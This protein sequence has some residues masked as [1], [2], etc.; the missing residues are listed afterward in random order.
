MS[1]FLHTNSPWWTLKGHGI[2]YFHVQLSWKRYRW[3]LLTINILIGSDLLVH[4]V[5]T[6]CTSP[7]KQ[8][9]KCWHHWSGSRLS[10]VRGYISVTFISNMFFHHTRQVIHS[11]KYSITVSCAR[12]LHIPL[13]SG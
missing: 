8:T 13:P 9:L 1:L 10:I 6:Y 3:K 11:L 12:S 4:I 2:K 7:I 5:M